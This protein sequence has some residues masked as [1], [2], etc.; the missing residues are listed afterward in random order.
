M[1]IPGPLPQYYLTLYG[2]VGVVLTVLD[3]PDA[4]AQEIKFVKDT[5]IFALEQSERDYLETYKKHKWLC[6]YRMLSLLRPSCLRGKSHGKPQN[7][8][9]IEPQDEQK[10][11]P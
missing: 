7:E 2:W 1:A 4:G 6:K 10:N 9:Q 5:L 3:K 11:D 8:P